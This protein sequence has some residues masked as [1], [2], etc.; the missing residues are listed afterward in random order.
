MREKDRTLVMQWLIAARSALEKS[1]SKTYIHV[2]RWLHDQ[3]VSRKNREAV[4]T[5]ARPSVIEALHRRRT[6][7]QKEKKR[8]SYAD[9]EE[10]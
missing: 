3:D 7:A 5:Q 9:R 4:R 2:L 8:V 10:R 6:D 1:A